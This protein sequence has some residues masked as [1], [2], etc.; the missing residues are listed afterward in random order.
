MVNGPS[1]ATKFHIAIGKRQS[2]VDL[3]QGA[4]DGLEASEE[5]MVN[6]ISLVFRFSLKPVQTPL[7]PHFHLSENEVR[8]LGEL[9]SVRPLP[10]LKPLVRVE[11]R[12]L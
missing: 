9:K 10:R 7:G 2:R 12:T 11:Q 1:L 4:C 6:Q 5:L 3:R 8:T